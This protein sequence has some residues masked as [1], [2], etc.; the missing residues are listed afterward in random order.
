M[1]VVRRILVHRVYEGQ[2]F[3]RATRDRPLVLRVPPPDG[4]G[5]LLP[6]GGRAVDVLAFPA[7]PA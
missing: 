6:A 5:V 2:G 1:V 7:R 4:D 3:R